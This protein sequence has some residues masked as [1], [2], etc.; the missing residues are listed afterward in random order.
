MRFQGCMFI[1]R[2]AEGVHAYLLKCRKGTC[3]SVRMLKGYMVNKRLGT[4]DITESTH[5]DPFP[6]NVEN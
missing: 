5:Q 4:P 2:N 3:S 1:R 6:H